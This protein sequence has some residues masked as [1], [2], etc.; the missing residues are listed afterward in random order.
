[1]KEYK[2]LIF[3]DYFLKAYKKQK[4]L[5]CLFGSQLVPKPLCI[6]HLQIPH[7]ILF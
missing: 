7:D 5:T 4:N 6:K 3:K 2:S 1:M